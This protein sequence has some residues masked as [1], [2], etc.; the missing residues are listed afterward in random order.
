VTCRSQA[1]SDVSS[2]ASRGVWPPACIGKV[3]DDDDGSGGSG[4]DDD[5]EEDDDDNDDDDDDDD[6]NVTW[7]FVNA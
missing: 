6:C 3:G 7:F 5:G 2:A 4:G 1:G